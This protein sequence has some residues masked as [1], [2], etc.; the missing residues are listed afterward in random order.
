M[1]IIHTA[2]KEEMSRVAADI[3]AKQITQNP[4]SVLGL[5]TGGT[6]LG[7]YKILSAMYAAGKLDFSAVKTINLD[8]YVGLSAEN[9]NSY[10]FYM[11]KNFFDHINIQPQNTHVPNGTAK[12]LQAECSTYDRLIDTLGP[13][14]IQL[15]GIGLNGHIGFCEPCE[16]FFTSTSVIQLSAS[17]IQA[18]SVYYNDISLVP[19]QAITISVKQIMAAKKILLI[20][21]GA[22]KREILYKALYGLITAKLPASLLQL[23]QNVTIVEATGLHL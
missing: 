10:R 23:H 3:L 11:Q 1:T 5:A 19:R 16:E 14:D 20:A 2:N 12:N 9:S 18:N 13:P 21:E 22:E 15:L 8:E 4:Q 6:P 17:T 7:V